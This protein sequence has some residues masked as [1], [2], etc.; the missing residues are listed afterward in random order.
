MRQEHAS[1]RRTPRPASFPMLRLVVFLFLSSSCFSPSSTINNISL[2]FVLFLSLPL[3]RTSCPLV[4]RTRL[5][6]KHP[7]P[8]YGDLSLPCHHPPRPVVPSVL[9][10][11][12]QQQCHHLLPLSPLRTRPSESSQ[13]KRKLCLQVFPSA[14][15][16]KFSWVLE[17]L[18]TPK[19]IAEVTLAIA[20]RDHRIAAGASEVWRQQLPL[21]YRRR[22]RGKLQQLRLR[23]TLPPFRCFY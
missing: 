1:R 12:S 2:P 6:V 21:F 22:N 13:T 15:I 3:Y 11:L 10:F 9:M 8:R 19:A 14:P 18:P 4:L 16:Q 17:I 20:T 5:V 7:I 23:R